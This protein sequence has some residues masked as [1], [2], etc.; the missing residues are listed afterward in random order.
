MKKSHREE[1]KQQL[2]QVRFKSEFHRCFLFKESL[3]PLPVLVWYH[4]YLLIK[5]YNILIPSDAV[6]SS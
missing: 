1:Y 4:A 3:I 5:M 6:T 2:Q